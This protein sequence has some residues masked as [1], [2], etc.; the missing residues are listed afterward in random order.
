MRPTRRQP[1]TGFTLIELL[2]VIA[3]I[4]ILIALLLPA[5]QQAREAAR[6]TQCRNNLKQFGLAFH[7]YHDVYG[8][9][10]KTRGGVNAA[11]TGASLEVTSVISWRTA[12][13]PYMEQTNIYNQLDFNTSPYD[14]VNDAA[15]ANIIPGFTCPSA[16]GEPAMVTWTIPGGTVLGSGFPPTAS[17]WTMTSGRID[18]ES[19]N[20]IRGD[21]STNAY[22]GTSYTGSRAGAIGWDLIVVDIP[23]IVAAFGGGDL[24]RG[25]KIRDILDGTSNTILIGELASRN[26]L[27]YRRTK[28]DATSAP[29]EFIAQQWVGG[30]AWGDGFT[31]N[32]I[33]GRNFDG[34]PGADGGLCGVNCSNY[35]GA[36]WYSWH[37][38][39]AQIALCD[40]SVRFISENIDALTYASLI[41]AGR[42]EVLGEF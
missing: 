6:R 16:Q 22:A 11:G 17:T 40:G 12:L 31:E 38:G 34:T 37:T 25:S 9:F 42:G 20:G 1:R 5:V 13:L 33:A 26:D 28:Q 19:A 39:G 24:S 41:T 32:W 36:G 15:Y 18:Y 10:A 8:E 23:P 35:R 2:V 29:A 21:F 3:I 7:N 30:G 27:Y 14:G 4:A